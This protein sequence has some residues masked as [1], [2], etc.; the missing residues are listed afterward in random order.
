MTTTKFNPTHIMHQTGK[1]DVPVIILEK[2]DV[3]W[4]VIDENCNR[5][6]VG[7]DNVWEYQ[8]WTNLRNRRG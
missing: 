4:L 3:L 1:V 5:Y 2:R 6:W 8:M 7:K